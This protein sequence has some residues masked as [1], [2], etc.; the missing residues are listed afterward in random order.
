MLRLETNVDL[1]MD[2][3]TSSGGR[4]FAPHEVGELR[5]LLTSRN[6]A[7]MERIPTKLYQGWWMLAVVVSLLSLEWILRKAAGLP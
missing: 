5:E 4:M 7:E 6:R 3:A 1:L 2:L